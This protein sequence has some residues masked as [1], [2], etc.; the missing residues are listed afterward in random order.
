MTL[1]KSLVHPLQ[2]IVLVVILLCFFAC[3]KEELNE[4]ENSQAGTLK[5]YSGLDGWGWLIQLSDSTKLE[6]M[7]LEDFDIELVNN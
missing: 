2:N 4:C 3:E 1:L 6:P 7:N 5:D